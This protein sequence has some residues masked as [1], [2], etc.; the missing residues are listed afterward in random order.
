[1]SIFTQNGPPK[2]WGSRTVMQ[3]ESQGTNREGEEAA[4]EEKPA[5]AE[6]KEA[7]NSKRES[8]RRSNSVGR[9]NNAGLLERRKRGS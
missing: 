6:V 3:A 9:P 8:Q 5:G 2:N 1:M 7:A 4:E